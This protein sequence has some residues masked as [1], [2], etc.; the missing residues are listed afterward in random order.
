MS[1]KVIWITGASS[2]IGE[3]SVYKFVKEGYQVILSARNQEGLEKVKSACAHPA[4]CTVIPLDL[5]DQ[6]SFE[7]K[8]KEAIAAFGQIDII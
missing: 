7:E 8:T 4:N 1:K 3:A 5:L 2:G 6:A